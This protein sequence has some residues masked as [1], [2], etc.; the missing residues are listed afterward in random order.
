MPACCRCNGTGR[1]RN[2]SC[3]KGGKSCTNCFPSKKGT[4][5]NLVP[6]TVNESVPASSQDCFATPI[7]SD[8][9]DNEITFSNEHEAENSDTQPTPHDTILAKANP[10]YRKLSAPNFIWSSVDGVSFM[11]LIDEAY[12]EIVQWRPNLFPLPTRSSSNHFVREC[13]RLILAYV[14][15]SPLESVA[16]KALMVMPTLLL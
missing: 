7:T 8:S 11:E 3:R 2:C 16:L 13:T 6:T 12:H 10:I 5:E 14:D 15:E 1:C 4:C 9:S